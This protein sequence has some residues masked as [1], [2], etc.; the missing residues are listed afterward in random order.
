MPLI[1]FFLTVAFSL[2]ALTVSAELLCQWESA[3]PNIFCGSE[4]RAAVCEQKSTLGC[5]LSVAATLFCSFP[6]YALQGFRGLLDDLFD[7]F[8]FPLFVKNFFQALIDHFSLLTLVAWY[9]IWHIRYLVYMN[10]SA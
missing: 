1:I 4:F 5:H 10:L 7:W 6:V 2:I 3:D 9:A 8:I